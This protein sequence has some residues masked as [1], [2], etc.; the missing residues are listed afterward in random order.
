MK[1]NSIIPSSVS[2][3]SPPCSLAS[4]SNRASLTIVD[5]DT[6]HEDLSYKGS[7]A[8][9]RLPFRSIPTQMNGMAR[10]SKRQIGTFDLTKSPNMKDRNVDSQ[11]AIRPAAVADKLLSIISNDTYRITSIVAVILALFLY[12]ISR[13]LPYSSF[14]DV[15]EVALITIFIFFIVD[16]VVQS[17]VYQ[18]YIGSFFFWL[19][20]VGTVTLLADLSFTYK[21]FG[22]QPA[23][24]TVAR[25]GRAGRA[26]RTATTLRISRMVMWVRITRLVRVA[27]VLRQFR[28]TIQNS[29][30][31]K[32]DD[33]SSSSEVPS[34]GIMSLHIP[35]GDDGDNTTNE[36]WEDELD[37][38]HDMEKQEKLAKRKSKMHRKS[39]S[40]RR[41]T[42]KRRS[43]GME[44]DSLSSSDSQSSARFAKK[45]SGK[46][47]M[48]VADSI[49]RNV[50]FGILLTVS[51]VPIFSYRQEE[52]YSALY[53]S[54]DLLT[55][56]SQST[57]ISND[58]FNSIISTVLATSEFGD[59]IYFLEVDGVEYRNWNRD[60]L[61][62]TEW[63]LFEDDTTTIKL[64]ISETTRFTH[65]MSIGLTALVVMLFAGL[66]FTISRQISKLVV[67]P[68]EKMTQIVQEFT[69]NICLLGGDLDNQHRIVTEL[70][71]TEVIEAAITT[72]GN[73]FSS[74]L[75]QQNGTKKRRQSLSMISIKENPDSESMPHRKQSLSESASSLSDGIDA[76]SPLPL[77]SQLQ[78]KMGTTL[79]TSRDS[80]LEI[81]I[82]QST[83]VNIE[84][85]E[86]F[87]RIRK[88]EK[89]GDIDSFCI[90]RKQ[91]PE[92]QSLTTVMDHPIASEYFRAYCKSR[93]LGES[94]FFVKAVDE[95]R[96]GVKAAFTKVY[97]A[98][99]DDKASKKVSVTEKDRKK[100]QEQFDDNNFGIRIFDGIRREIVASLSAEAFNNFEQSKFA[101][102]YLKSREKDAVRYAH[103][104][105][106]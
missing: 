21:I 92:L 80:V 18:S 43:S 89:C 84:D 73:I 64:D 99:I 59:N 8:E 77:Q 22:Y 20:L 47:G 101:V 57:T 105:K 46:I 9:S 72:L 23:D 50:V 75:N 66:A 11:Y 91:V 88:I 86:I 39:G 45:H 62:L 28:L 32:D 15:V 67:L 25:G 49:A 34:H 76:I 17:I 24:M 90:G 60:E 33:C 31:S 6:E 56:Q 14:D 41:S 2:S 13:T 58:T 42:I 48:R 83:R 87:A 1:T 10:A 53:L 102:A 71:E 104:F 103:I 5:R 7:D 68:I 51:L 37:Q 65:G 4:A 40:K 106:K 69:K 79:L 98:H 61:R 44:S 93:L 96:V 36:V 74:L 12:D 97:N 30:K 19:D 52:S 3:G 94:F 29:F 81:Q 55:Q 100:L 82:K 38:V 85:E 27:R 70:L 95:Y 54:R 63:G 78:R 35:G 16:L 26:A